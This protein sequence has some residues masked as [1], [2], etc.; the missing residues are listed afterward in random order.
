MVAVDI[1]FSFMVFNKNNSNS[2]TDQLLL[3]LM[4]VDTDLI[5]GNI[6]KME[7]KLGLACSQSMWKV[8]I[9][10]KEDDLPCL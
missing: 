9:D 3:L 2:A 8:Q 4:Y 5:S 10:I 7:S 6:F 1:N